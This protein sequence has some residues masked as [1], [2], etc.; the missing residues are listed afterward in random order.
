M[1][2]QTTDL[3]WPGPKTKTVQMVRVPRTRTYAKVRWIKID[4]KG[5]P[6]KGQGLSGEETCQNN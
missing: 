3:T 5:N 2:E 6:E 4:V 1:T